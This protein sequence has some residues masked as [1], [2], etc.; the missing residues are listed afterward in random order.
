MT[1]IVTS[2][3]SSTHPSP[4]AFSA[5]KD[6]TDTTAIE[7]QLSEYLQQRIDSFSIDPEMTSAPLGNPG[8]ALHA[9][10]TLASRVA[11]ATRSYVPGRPPLSVRQTKVAGTPVHP[12]FRGECHLPR[13]HSTCPSGN[14][15]HLLARFMFA[16]WIEGTSPLPSSRGRSKK[17]SSRTEG[18]RPVSLALTAHSEEEVHEEV[19][20][21]TC[22]RFLS[23]SSAGVL[24][25]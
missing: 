11:P 24:H 7:Y 8:Q 18:A 5:L 4:K 3:D 14:Q 6:R 17:G 21:S 23:L 2:A 19:G 13:P 16:A 9:R 20:T 25:G 1:H 22:L 10:L 12:R 15:P